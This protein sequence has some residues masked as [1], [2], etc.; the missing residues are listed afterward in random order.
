[1]KTV[2]LASCTPQEVA[3]LAERRRRRQDRHDEVWQGEY[4]MNPAA[5]AHHG[6]LGLQLSGILAAAAAQRKLRGLL[7][8]NIGG[9][10]DYRVPDLGLVRLDQELAVWNP[11]AAVV[12]EVVSP[13]DESWLKFDFY[14]AH[15]VDEVVIVDGETNTVH[16]FALGD[17]TYERVDRSE[18]LDLAVAEV[19][20]A[21]DWS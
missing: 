17:R 1:M 7:E 4:H 13:G 21:I 5:H 18:L 9:P 3:M 8:F 14:A 2:V 11:T 19:E 12:V 6:W 15:D 16:W 20:E 10:D